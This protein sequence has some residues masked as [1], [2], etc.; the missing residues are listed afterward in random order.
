VP[1]ERNQSSGTYN[2]GPPMTAEQKA[3]ERARL[4]AEQERQKAASD[5]FMAKFLERNP[6]MRSQVPGFMKAPTDASSSSSGTGIPTPKPT[7][8]SATI[9]KLGFNPSTGVLHNAN[10]DRTSTLCKER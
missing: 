2:V 6:G 8:D 3:R 10:A 9:R 5:A 4:A 1:K 7:F